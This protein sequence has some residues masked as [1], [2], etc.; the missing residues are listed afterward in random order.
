MQRPNDRRVRA[1]GSE[2]FGPGSALGGMA[3][4][5][6]RLREARSALFWRRYALRAAGAAGDGNLA[7]L[8]ERASIALDAF[9]LVKGVRSEKAL[10]ATGTDDDG[11][12]LDDE[13][14]GPLCRSFWSRS[15]P[16]LL[17]RRA[18]T[19]AIRFPTPAPS[20]RGGAEN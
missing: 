10:A 16:A 17:L 20:I 18:R 11:H 5:R 4:Q 12:V 19:G 7:M 2:G 1:R 9:Q 6:K 15:E 14:R 8:R 13:Q 3:S